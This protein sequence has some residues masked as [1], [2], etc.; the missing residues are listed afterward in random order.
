MKYTVSNF[1]FPVNKNGE[2]NWKL[3]IKIYNFITLIII[4]DG[5]SLQPF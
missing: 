2:E 1:Y 3:S 4:V 5:I